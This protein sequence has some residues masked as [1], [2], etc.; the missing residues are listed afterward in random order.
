MFTPTLNFNAANAGGA[1]RPDRLAPGVIPYG[2][3]SVTRWFDVT[4]F[5]APNGF[6]F[7]NSGRNIL[8]GPRF[9]QWDFSLFKIIPIRERFRVQIRAESFNVFNHTNFALPNATI[10][11]AAAGFISGTVSSPRQNQFAMKLVF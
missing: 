2:D 7:G 9:E 10:G 11:T 5:A 4:A 8:T 6:A 1:Q 3:R